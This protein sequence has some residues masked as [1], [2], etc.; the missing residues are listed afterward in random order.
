[1]KIRKCDWYT[2]KFKRQGIRLL[3]SKYL[4]RKGMLAHDICTFIL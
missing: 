1:M 3:D 4:T 2:A